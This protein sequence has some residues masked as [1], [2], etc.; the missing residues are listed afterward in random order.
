MK[1]HGRRSFLELAVVG[2]L[3]ILE[4]G[5]MAFSA[6]QPAKP[7]PAAKPGSDSF[8]KLAALDRQKLER[9]L[10]G[11]KTKNEADRQAKEAEITALGRGVVPSLVEAAHQKNK[12]QEPS[13]VS[14]LD[15]LLAADDVAY[16]RGL[17]KDPAPAI[18][19]FAAVKLA[20]LKTPAAGGAAEDQELV[21]LLAPLVSDSDP[22]V[23]FTAAITLAEQH[24]PEGFLVLIE[25]LKSD[26]KARVARVEKTLPLLKGKE[27]YKMVQSEMQGKAKDP[28]R[29]L[30]LLGAV[31]LVGDPASGPLVAESL[32]ESSS[33]LQEATVNA[34][35]RVVDGAEPLEFATVFDLV[36]EVE[37]WKQRLGHK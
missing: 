24:R 28:E 32:G 8:P 26:D 1:R 31:G 3:F 19:A 27:A 18:R 21:D 4:T 16:V 11:L 5:G 15:K 7:A 25:A 23:K 29:R 37:T 33:K 13:L 35:R 2:G 36:K 9:L 22:D 30:L 10:E 14:A 20:K 34:L 6:Q 17:L 12:L